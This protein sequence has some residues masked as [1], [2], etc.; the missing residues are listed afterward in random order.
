MPIQSQ[1]NSLCKWRNVSWSLDHCILHSIVQLSRRWISILWQALHS[2]VQLSGQT[3]RS[4]RRRRTIRT[5]MR[6][7]N[8]L[9][10]QSLQ[11]S[12]ILSAIINETGTFISN[13][14]PTCT[15][16][17]SKD[18]LVRLC[19]VVY[20]SSIRQSVYSY[21]RTQPT[22]E[23]QNRRHPRKWCINLL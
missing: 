4:W 9:T 13:S 14:S 16:H 12:N 6:K 7:W 23:L 11:A 5:L 20:L 10:A 19:T 18:V 2:H 8:G 17:R 22:S 1:E 21:A 15:I 3:K